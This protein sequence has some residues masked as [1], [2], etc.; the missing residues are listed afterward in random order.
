M[1][2]ENGANRD[3]KLAMRILKLVLSLFLLSLLSFLLPSPFL[4]TLLRHRM[5]ASS[6]STHTHTHTHAYATIM[7]TTGILMVF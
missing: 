1:K 2:E 6:Y 4:V 5:L 7:V 3:G